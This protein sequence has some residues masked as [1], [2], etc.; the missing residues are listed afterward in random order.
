VGLISTKEFEPITFFHVIIF[1]STQPKTLASIFTMFPPPPGAPAPP[2]AA[3]Y[4][5]YGHHS[6]VFF[7]PHQQPWQLPSILHLLAPSAPLQQ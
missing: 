1:I 2:V 4:I 6:S 5:K 3:A 7:F